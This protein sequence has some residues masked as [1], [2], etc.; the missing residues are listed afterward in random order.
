MKKIFL[1]VG[2]RPEAIKM[3]P[4]FKELKKSGKADVRLIATGQHKEMLSQA[5]A[6]F[7]LQP[8]INM[9]VMS[10]GQTLAGLSARLFEQADNLLKEE[11]PDV[12]L[13]QG[14]TTTVQVVSLCAFYH[15]I[16][17]G[18]IEAGLRSHNMQAP[19]PEELNRRVTALASTWHFAPTELSR[20]NLLN[21]GVSDNAIL[22]TGNT[23]IDAL[24]WMRNEVIREKPPLPPAIEQALATDHPVIL[25]TGH[26]RENFGAG[27]RQI[28]QALLE[29][30]GKFPDA[31]LVYPVHLNPNVRNDVMRLLGNTPN[32]LLEDPL[33]YKPF[34][35]LMNAC[36]L[37]L[38]D[39][40][41]IQEEGPSLGKPVLI[42]RD[43]TERPEGI[44][45]GVNKLVGTDTA[46]IIDEVSALLSDK[47]AY[48]RMAMAQNPYGDGKASERIAQFLQS[49]L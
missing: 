34:I 43:V 6:D 26:R 30:A 32:I 18:H 28:C 40:G 29:I 20:Q 9:Q 2:T 4:V 27:F 22:V 15:R 11:K 36:H 23:V 42:M 25:V 46:R 14:D 41:G 39:S 49:R 48:A 44:E 21:E 37:I 8:D 10:A 35:R 38:T 24:L 19:F 7:H 5:L 16:P 45:A 47:A 1:F 31:K 33:S 13:V 17:V 12:V 3:A